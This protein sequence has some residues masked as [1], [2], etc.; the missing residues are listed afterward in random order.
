MLHLK[1]HMLTAV[2]V[3]WQ[4]SFLLVV[5]C[6][7][8]SASLA[9]PSMYGA[10]PP[11]KYPAPV[12]P[13]KYEAPAPTMYET[14]T[15]TTAKYETPTTTTTKYE[16]PTTPKYEAPAK[17][18]EKKEEYPMKPEYK[19]EEYP[20]PAMKYGGK[21]YK[22][23]IEEDSEEAKSEMAEDPKKTEDPIRFPAKVV[24]TIRDAVIQDLMSMMDETAVNDDDTDFDGLKN[25]FDD[26]Q[27]DQ[28]EEEQTNDDLGLFTPEMDSAMD[29]DI[30]DDKMDTF[31]D[32]S[33]MKY[34]RILI[35]KRIQAKMMCRHRSNCGRCLQWKS[36]PMSMKR[37][38]ITRPIARPVT[39]FSPKRKCFWIRVCYWFVFF[40][41]LL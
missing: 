8:L 37:R 10:A 31:A 25:I 26:G 1:I 35:K 24:Q 29:D 4:A 9:D 13:P 15:T 6:G 19:K 22:R 23:S 39:R 12:A 16:V 30:S 27:E 36:R 34:I 14:P 11:A 40:F 21:K 38:W 28:D 18:E 33:M 17:Y 20:A 2:C 7:L 41:L 32:P 5:L 3:L